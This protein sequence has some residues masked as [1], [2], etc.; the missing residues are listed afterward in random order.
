MKL[1]NEHRDLLKRYPKAIFHLRSQLNRSRLVP[2]FGAGVGVPLRLPNWA[3]LVER[4]RDHKD[5]DGA[6]LLSSSTS[7]VST[8]QLL[9]Q[10]FRYCQIESLKIQEGYD[11]EEAPFVDER[12]VRKNWWR[13]IHEC[14]YQGAK[15]YEDH[16]YL[17]SY[18][19][20]IKRSPL[21][22]N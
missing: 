2:F 11:P 13:I 14:L 21:T 12:M 22:V 9:F 19:P 6:S 5:I 4:I 17:A 1:T 20:I 3:Q 16:P 7:Q 18:L 15:S 10:H 8:T